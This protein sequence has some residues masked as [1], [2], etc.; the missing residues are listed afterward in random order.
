[1]RKRIAILLVLVLILTVSLCACKGNTAENDA[2][3]AKATTKTEAKNEEDKQANVEEKQIKLVV[4]DEFTEGTMNDANELMID[5][6]EEQY[7]NVTV[8]RVPKSMDI[9]AET[10]KGAFLAG[11]APDVFYYEQGIGACGGFLKGGYLLNLPA[12]YEE[13][14]WNKNLSPAAS[15]TGRIGD[16]IYGVGCELETMGLYYNKDIFEQLNISEPNTIEELDAIC[17]TIK[18]AGYIPFANTMGEG[19]WNN[20]NTIGVIM[21]SYMTTEEIEKVMLEDASWDMPSVRKAI[22]K[23]DD[24]IK[25][26]YFI[27]H[28]ETDA[29]NSDI[30]LRQEA[31]IT[32]NGNWMV[33][34]FDLKAEF[35]VGVMHFPG[36]EGNDKSAQV[37]FVGS[38][39]LVNAHSE[40]VDMALNYVDFFV[41]RADTASIWINQAGKIPPY[42]GEYEADVSDL[43]KDVLV[44]LGDESLNNTSGINMWLG[45]N[46]FDFFS[47]AGQRLIVGGLTVD[48]FIDELIASQQKDIDEQ[49]TKASFVLE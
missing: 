43:M 49:G 7:P 46:G 16:Y 29:E 6:F 47:T 36:T 23:I 2:A 20:M 40:N 35:E 5:M 41:N 32:I 1:M 9:L 37:N 12:A 33:N 38:G 18:E 24:W 30:F 22:E 34:D 17:A 15:A 31:A 10:L 13:Y 14:G 26:D 27:P 4:W 48:T 11:D 28:P 44:L 25:K 3:E 45:T 8:E 21:Y 39:Y 19:W 42:V